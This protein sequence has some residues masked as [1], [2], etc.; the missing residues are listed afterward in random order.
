MGI[1]ALMM[2]H[3][4]G[5]ERCNEIR[6]R[7]QL[8]LGGSKPSGHFVTMPDGSKQELS[9]FENEMADILIRKIKRQDAKNRRIDEMYGHVHKRK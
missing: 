9:E 3:A 7:A 5:P 2:E 1:S 8:A 6:R 4:L